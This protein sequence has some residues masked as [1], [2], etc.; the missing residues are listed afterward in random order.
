MAVRLTNTTQSPN[1]IIK[2]TQ[3]AVFSVVTPEQ[4]QFVTLSMIPEGNPDLT[5]YRNEILRTNKPEQQNNTF[6]FLTPK[7]S[8]K[9]GDH[10]TKQTRILRELTELKEKN[11]T[12]KMKQN[13][14]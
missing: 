10:A 5:I 2:K 11:L 7:N 4:S 13:P 1:L 12:Q 8:V 6:W 9:I 14:E 3:S